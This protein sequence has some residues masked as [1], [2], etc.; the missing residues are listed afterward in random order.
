[1]NG[2]LGWRA[3]GFVLGPPVGLLFSDFAQ[4]LLIQLFSFSTVF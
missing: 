4:V 3:R 1:M 2:S